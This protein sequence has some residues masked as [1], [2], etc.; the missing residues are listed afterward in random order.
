MSCEAPFLTLPPTRVNRFIASAFQSL[1]APRTTISEFSLAARSRQSGDGAG[2][3]REFEN[4][5]SGV[6]AIDDVDQAAIVGLDIVG[7]DRDLAA[8][9]AVDLTQ[10]LSVASVI[11]GMK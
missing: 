2:L 8:V 11:G 3:A 7:L 1:T 6:G 10:R 9:G 5:H 4:M